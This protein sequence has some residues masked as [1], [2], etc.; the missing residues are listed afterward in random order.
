MD[1][2]SIVMLLSALGQLAVKS[3]QSNEAGAYQERMDKYKRQEEQRQRE[4]ARQQ[5]RRARRQAL[6]SAIG[7]RTPTMPMPGYVARTE[8]EAP[9]LA[10]ADIMGTLLGAAGSIA[11][12]ETGQGA[13]N[14]TAANLWPTTFGPKSNSVTLPRYTPTYTM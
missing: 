7:A 13:I 5:E 4:Y 14:S 12:S 10:G 2:A 8:P 11:G 6:A 3:Y 1:P 9:N